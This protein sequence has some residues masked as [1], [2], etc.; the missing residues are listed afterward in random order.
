MTYDPELCERLVADIR[1]EVARTP[2]AAHRAVVA[3]QLESARRRVDELLRTC[4]QL[5]NETPFPDEIKGWQEQRAK[6][7]AEVGSLKATVAERDRQLEAARREVERLT[8]QRFSVT[9]GV[10]LRAAIM[11]EVAKETDR[12]LDPIA[13]LAIANR[14]AEQCAPLIDAYRDA[15]DKT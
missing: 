3:D 1:A 11:R 5:T 6:L 14:V 13:Y 15:K 12:E 10:A 8:S 2:Y 4:V 9:D 7:V